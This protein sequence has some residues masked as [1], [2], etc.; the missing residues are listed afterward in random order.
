MAD[1][2]RIIGTL[3]IHAVTGGMDALYTRDV[4]TA[5]SGYVKS[6]KNVL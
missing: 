4:I 3:N 2:M 5:P 6:F 1:A